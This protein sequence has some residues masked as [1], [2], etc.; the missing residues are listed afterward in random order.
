M[1]LLDTIKHSI[2]IENGAQ[3]RLKIRRMEGA[4]DMADMSSSL[5][6]GNTPHASFLPLASGPPTIVP[7]RLPHKHNKT[8]HDPFQSQHSGSSQRPSA[9][10][11]R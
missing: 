11:R 5:S 9:P 2:S 1:D 4:A 7:L 6:A 8:H 10:R 3:T